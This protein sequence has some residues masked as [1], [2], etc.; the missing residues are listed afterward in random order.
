MKLSEI[1]NQYITDDMIEMVLYH[2]PKLEWNECDCLIIFGCHIK[3]LLD[4]RINCAIEI[5]RTKKVEFVLLTGGIGS[6]GDFNEAQYMKE[7]LI[8]EGIPKNKIM[9]EDQSKT[10]KENVV[11][12][13]EILKKN[14]LF[15]DKK[16][17]VVSNQ[18]HL[19]RIHLEF[20]KYIKNEHCHL[21]YEYPKQE[22]V[23]FENVQKDYK[24]QDLAKKQVIKIVDYIKEG[25][26]PDE[27]TEWDD[28]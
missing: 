21:L 12:S 6:K 20:K 27:D 5:L 11:N 18:A 2:T 4:D 28:E 3:R 17:V 1:N 19:R 15:Q 7:K 14:N 9:I 25:K 8:M 22:L 13:I 23:F 16:I 24:L 10:T 26:L